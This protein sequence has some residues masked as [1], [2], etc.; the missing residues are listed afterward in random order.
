MGKALKHTL[1]VWQ[2]EEYLVKP[3]MEVIEA[4][5][6]SVCLMSLS[7]KFGK[8][9]IPLSHVSKVL[10]ECGRAAGCPASKLD[11]YEALSGANGGKAQ[12]E[13]MSSAT[14]IILSLFPTHAPKAEAE[15]AKKKPAKRK[16]KAKA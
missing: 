1:L 12:G 9:M 15:P 3:T 4:I 13:L 8:G 16:P 7:S 2:G 6:D 5:E 11:Y 14:D 10:Y